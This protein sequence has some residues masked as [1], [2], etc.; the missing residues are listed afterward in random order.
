MEPT[1][2]HGREKLDDT[3]A[4][5]RWIRHIDPETGEANHWCVDGDTEHHD[6]P[7]ADA[8]AHAGD[9]ADD[10]STVDDW[11]LYEPIA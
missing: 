7:C 1:I 2:E 6:E 3:I 10:V 5:H 9:H 4:P 11:P 8:E